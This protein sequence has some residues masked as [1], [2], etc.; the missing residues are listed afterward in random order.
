MTWHFIGEPDV[1]YELQEEDT[2]K[3]SV[4]Q[5]ETAQEVFYL[6]SPLR[7]W[8][9]EIQ[10]PD[11]ISSPSSTPTGTYLTSEE[12]TDKKAVCDTAPTQS[13]SC[14][15][16]DLRK[17]DASPNP[18]LLETSGENEDDQRR[19]RLQ[20]QR[21]LPVDEGAPEEPPTSRTNLFALR[22][23]VATRGGGC[24]TK[25]TLSAPSIASTHTYAFRTL[26]HVRL[27]TH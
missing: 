1:L 15:A 3:T 2:S 21:S 14:A 10:P 24:S 5:V 6:R 25:S 22:D 9:A 20:L 8:F 17:S 12:T 26:P 7:N 13:S 4:V 19:L 16:L 18:A 11:L 23:A 27:H